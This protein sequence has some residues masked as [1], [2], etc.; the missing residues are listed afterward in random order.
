MNAPRSR[1]A[2]PSALWKNWDVVVRKNARAVAVIE[3]ESGRTWS[4]AE[5]HARAEALAA[6]PLARAAGERV[7]FS[8]ANGAE[9][10]ALFIALQRVGAAA[11]PLDPSLTPKQ[12]GSLADALRLRFVWRDGGLHLA[13][14]ASRAA[15][16]MRVGKLTSGSSGTPRIIRCSAEHLIADGA[17]IGR[18]MHIRSSDR[19]LALIPLGHSYGLGNLVAP[20]LGQGTSLICAP[21]F[22]PHQISNWIKKHRATVLPT[23]PAML[24][25]LAA[26]PGRA[27]L[28]PLR[29]V[30][31]AGARL[32]TETARDFHRRFG[33]RVH[34]FYGSS[35]TGGICYDQR[36]TVS[37]DNASVGRAL[38]GVKVTLTA[39]GRIRVTSR[40][41]AAGRN[42][43]FTLPDFGRLN[44][45]GELEILGR[46]GRIANIGG[47]NLHPR[48]IETRLAQMPGVT[49]AWVQVLAKAERDYLVAAVESSRPRAEIVDEFS[50]LVAPWQRPRFWLVLP[51]LPRTDRGKLDAPVLRARLGASDLKSAD[52]RE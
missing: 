12:Q 10:I 3:A 15:G 14:T 48:E 22:V 20:L 19:N 21:A 23:V 26:L 28:A 24:R 2:S 18:T 31:S 4:R 50:Q 7:G 27:R 34:N 9:W 33:L 44:P 29:L 46:A 32:P 30:I 37:G 16:S 38:A 17:N 11:I 41:V 5:L 25:L 43:A 6:G 36:A 45:R 49:D 47:R 1:P 52:A 35:E 13:C 39:R 8:L 42:G 51:Q 40:A